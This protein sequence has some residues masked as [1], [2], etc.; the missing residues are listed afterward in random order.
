M[1]IPGFDYFVLGEPQRTI[2]FCEQCLSI[3]R[4]SGDRRGEGKAL[5]IMSLASER[6]RDRNQA[7]AL[8]GAALKLYEQTANSAA[9]KVRKQLE[10]WHT[11]T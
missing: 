1:N 6:L 2:E 5:F 8:A 10:K 4:K 3:L 11:K 7:I 9:Y